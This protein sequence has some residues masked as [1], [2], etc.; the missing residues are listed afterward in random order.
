MPA[1]KPMNE[2]VLITGAAGFL[3]RHVVKAAIEEGL[4]VRATDRPGADLSW[5]RELGALVTHADLSHRD[6]VSRL[7]DEAR[8][9]AHLAAVHRLGWDKERLLRANLDTAINVA[10][11]AASAGVAYFVHC[12]SADTYGACSRVPMREHDPQQPEN[13][14]AFSKLA[15]EKALEEIAARHGMPLTIVRP[16]II[17]GPH[18]IYASGALCALPIILH[19]RMGFLPRLRGGP[20]INAVHVEDAAGAIVFA[21]SH[22]EMAGQVYNVSDDDWLSAG[23][24]MH[25]TVDPLDVNW[26]SRTVPISKSALSFMSQ[27]LALLPGSGFDGFSR[28]LH[29]EWEEI[30]RDQG[31]RPVFEPSFDKGFASYGSGDHVYDNSKLKEAGY[32][33]RWPCYA[34]GYRATIEWYKRRRWIPRSAKAL[35]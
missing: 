15:T 13:N 7:F 18:G 5:A 28:R 8:A 30:V 4:V 17:Y 26:G 31:L 33:L 34:D 24:Y 27:A 19:R 29:S 32:R 2:Q 21:L 20:L 12:S 35:A 10:E 6:Q 16:S 25:A 11:E 3:G 14:Y 1:K 23:E 9:V 22:P